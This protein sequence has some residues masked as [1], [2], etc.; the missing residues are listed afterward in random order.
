MGKI[1]YLIGKSCTGKDSLYNIIKQDKELDLKPVI[2]Y[3]TR[4]IRDGETDGVGY[5]FV[6]EGSYRSYKQSGKII[7]EQVYHTMHGDWY[8]FTADD[9]NIDILQNSYL[10]TGVLESFAGT[11]EYYGN[12]AVIPIY[13]D[14]DD[15]ERLQ[16]ALNRERLPENGRYAEMCRRFLADAE[17][18]RE[19]RI[20][21]LGITKEARFVNDDLADCAKRIKEWIL[22]S[23]R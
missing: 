3:T 21:E 11:R 19:E 22:R 4:P 17:D 2:R 14:L 6:D 23:I 18:F 7:E 12:D 13:I 20:K 5:H 1:F 10:A 16:R 8:Y 9:G 15:G